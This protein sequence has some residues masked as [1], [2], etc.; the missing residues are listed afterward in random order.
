MPRASWR[1]GLLPSLSSTPWLVRCLRIILDSVK[2]PEDGLDGSA[3][4][5]DDTHHAL[6][7]EVDPV[8]RLK[9]IHSR[10]WLFRFSLILSSC[11]AITSF[12]STS[13]FFI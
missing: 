7:D 5:A 13:P 10:C 1:G 3:V 8:P 6:V 4:E 2:P 9:G 11:F 12:L